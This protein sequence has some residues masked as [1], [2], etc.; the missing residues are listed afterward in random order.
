MEISFVIPIFNER[1]NI[2]ILIKKLEETV[3]G[4][5]TEY[6]FILVDDGSTDSSD[7]VLMEESEGKP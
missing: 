2:P 5:Y 1:E 7:K 4:K 6:E 3:R